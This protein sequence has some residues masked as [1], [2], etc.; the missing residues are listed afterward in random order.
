VEAAT[1]IP[2]VAW[3]R[4]REQK[5]R[6]TLALTVCSKLPTISLVLLA[7]FG[8][9]HKPTSPLPDPLLIIHKRRADGPAQQST[10]FWHPLF[11]GTAEL[12]APSRIQFL[13]K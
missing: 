7:W 6:A 11:S 9:L 4:V 1:N 8:E 2:P 3:T 5:H 13:D 12:L 10:P